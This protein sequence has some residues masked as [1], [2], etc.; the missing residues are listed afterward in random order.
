M[1]IFPQNFFELANI[2]YFQIPH[3]VYISL[4]NDLILYGFSRCHVNDYI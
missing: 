4:P 1:M 3:R 2:T